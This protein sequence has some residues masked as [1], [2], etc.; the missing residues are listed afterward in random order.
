MYSIAFVSL[1]NTDKT[2]TVLSANGQYGVVVF[3]TS[4]Q[5]QEVGSWICAAGGERRDLSS[6]YKLILTCI[7]R[8]TEGHEDV[9]SWERIKR[10]KR[11]PRTE[12]K[13]NY[14]V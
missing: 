12:F 10:E 7:Y 14:N 1:E 13:K 4:R 3:K 11:R 6:G 2:G 9:I 5:R 8:I